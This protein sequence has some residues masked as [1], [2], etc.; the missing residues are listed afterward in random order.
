MQMADRFGVPVIESRRYGWRLS[1][2]RGRR[3]RPGRGYCRSTDCCL[4]LTVPMIA[5]IIGEGGS[6]GAVA[7]A[8]ANR[9]LMLEHAITA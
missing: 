6:G 3:A 9:V 5:V 2:H 8:S 1:G 7:M 4:S